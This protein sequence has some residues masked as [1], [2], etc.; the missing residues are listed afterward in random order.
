MA[1]IP[2]S[3]ESKDP[4]QMVLKVFEKLELMVD[5][6]RPLRMAQ[7]WLWGSQIVVKY[8]CR[9]HLENVSTSINLTLY[10]IQDEDEE[11]GKKN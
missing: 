6:A 4:E 10:Y 9:K 7:S 1:G 3:N 5:L 8:V 2:D 11:R